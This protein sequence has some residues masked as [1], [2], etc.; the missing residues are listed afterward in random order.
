MRLGA[1]FLGNLNDQATALTL[2][3]PLSPGDGFRY[4]VQ[5]TLLF[6]GHANYYNAD[7]NGGSLLL[8]VVSGDTVWAACSMVVKFKHASYLSLDYVVEKTHGAETLRACVADGEYPRD[9]YRFLCIAR[10]VCGHEVGGEL[11]EHQARL[12]RADWRGQLRGMKE[13]VDSV[14]EQ[15]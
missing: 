8:S 11:Y 4:M 1:G 10:Y 12:E 13:Q 5:A 3:S 6:G 2:F 14:R 9:A 15:L 7:E